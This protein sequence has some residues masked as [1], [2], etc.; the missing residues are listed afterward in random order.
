MKAVEEEKRKWRIF[1]NKVDTLDKQLNE[2]KFDTLLNQI[3]RALSESYTS[4]MTVTHTPTGKARSG[5]SDKKPR[6]PLPSLTCDV[7]NCSFTCKQNKRMRDHKAEAH[8]ILAEESVMDNS[9]NVSA[10]GLD[11]TDNVA[12]PESQEAKVH[13]S[14]DD[15]PHSTLKPVMSCP[16]EEGEKEEARGEKRKERREDDESDEEEEIETKRE[17]IEENS[18]ERST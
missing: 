4:E 6:T 15:H 14:M 1:S 7:G 3:D 11:L 12:T 13:Q 9:V 16:L 5:T 18:V 8:E 2:L 10:L 17:K